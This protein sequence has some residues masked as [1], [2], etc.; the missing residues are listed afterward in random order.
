ML[1]YLTRHLQVL[2]AT[3]GDMRR[4]P[5]STINTLMIVAITL[6]LPCL[7]YVAVKSAQTLSGNWQGRPQISIFLDG[8]LEEQE[9]QLIFEEIR[10]H[11]DI[12]LAEFVSPK[13]ALEEFRVLSGAS[14][15]GMAAT[16]NEAG[17]AP[18][19]LS[20]FDAELTFLGDNPLP[21]SIVVMPNKE[22]SQSDVLL[23]LKEQLS[24]IEGIESIRL[25][26]DWT[27]RFNAILSVASRVAIL[28]STLLAFALILIVGNT[29]KLLIINRRHEIEIIKLVG[30]TD[31]FVRRPFLYYGMLFGLFGSVITLALLLLAAKL[32]GQ[33]LAQLNSLYQN[34]ALIYQLSLREICAIL[35][36]GTARWSVAQHLRKIQPR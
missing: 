14:S 18:S 13:Q 4:T 34:D 22:S 20:G 32:I 16:T 27:D 19:R 33:P 12:E 17:D 23:E 31:A 6:L 8:S 3:L 29:I 25:D 28:L 1:T 5:T 21:P 11:P 10:L 26:L 36:I 2:F 9:A 24:K 7:L 15:E 30:G 35:L